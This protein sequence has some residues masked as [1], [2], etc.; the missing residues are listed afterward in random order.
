MYK[1]KLGGGIGLR[2]VFDIN[3]AASIKRFWNCCTS[4]SVWATWMQKHYCKNLSMWKLLSTLWTHIWKDTANVRQ[5]A[6]WH[7]HQEDSGIWVWTASPN[8]QFSFFSA[9]N[10]VRSP[11]QPFDLCNTV[12]FPSHSPKMACCLLRALNDR[13]LT[14]GRL[15]H[16]SVIDKDTCVL[17]SNEPETI[18]HLFF[19]CSYSAYIWSLC[20]LKL[21]LD[22]SVSS[23]QAE[24]LNVQEKFSKK[25]KCYVLARLVLGGAVW[26]ILE[27]KIQ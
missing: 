16:F 26:H 9:W 19:S 25:N 10:I 17:C 8:G 6:L 12:W 20:K 22:P 13:L 24:A 14:A 2:S 21:G 23:L 4:T 1:P 5:I 18:Q 7:R 27:G 15:K 3:R 11:S